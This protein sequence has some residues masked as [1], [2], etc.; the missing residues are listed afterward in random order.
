MKNT[1]PTTP[2]FSNRG[3]TSSSNLRNASDLLS[4]IDQETG[5]GRGSDQDNAFIN[6]LGDMESIASLDASLE[7]GEN[8][9]EDSD[10][11]ESS[12]GAFQF[13][14]KSKLEPKEEIQEKKVKISGSGGD[15]NAGKRRLFKVPDS[16]AYA[17]IYCFKTI[18]EGATFCTATKCQIQHK[19]KRLPLTC[20]CAYIKGVQKNTA[21][22]DPFVNTTLLEEDLSDDWLSSSKTK[23]EWNDLFT[24]V[25]ALARENMGFKLSSDDL[26]Y[27]ANV[28]SFAKNVQTPF[29]KNA[30]KVKN[31]KVERLGTLDQKLGSSIFESLGSNN[32]A[33]TIAEVVDLV[34]ALDSKLK[35][36]GA[37]FVNV[38]QLVSEDHIALNNFGIKVEREVDRFDSEIGVRPPNL[39]SL[40]D[41]PNLWST[42]G[43]LSN[44][45]VS[46]H[47]ST[48]DFATAIKD[49]TNQGNGYTDGQLNSFKHS[50]F[51]PL[52]NSV[53]NMQSDVSTI[54]NTVGD[55][56]KFAM[57]TGKRIKELRQSV[58]NFTPT[59]IHSVLN[60]TQ[61][62]SGFN[63]NWN[64]QGFEDRL[65]KLGEDVV[66]LKKQGNSRSHQ[67]S[68]IGLSEQ[69]RLNCFFT[70]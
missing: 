53:K 46:A 20:G 49:V 33:N 44:L 70:N 69:Q 2:R 17:S 67:V 48:L 23:E 3:G 35:L 41:A 12:I 50:S 6:A 38:H 64:S 60:Q 55:M 4:D 24:K 14:R 39:H 31:E 65:Q 22:V 1:F 9:G 13:L 28:S 56:E 51:N 58:Q 18:G 10:L 43:L 42:I 30:S 45:T 54:S 34:T 32:K 68:L 66:S 63:Q 8:G 59:P 7:A 19:G 25:R 11:E 62:T 21:F 27:E 36:L 29:R 26:E 37:S 16:E 52:A 40:V 47:D 15:G 57:T 5:T 61:P